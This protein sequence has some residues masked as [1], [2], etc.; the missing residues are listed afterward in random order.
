MFLGLIVIWAILGAI[1][2]AIASGKGREFWAWFIYG[3]FLFP[4]AL[5]HILVVH[6]ELSVEE[7]A[8]AAAL[9]IATERAAG[10]GRVACPHCAEKILPE[11]KVCRYCGRDVIPTEPAAAAP[12][13][14]VPDNI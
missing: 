9:R 2:G 7:V 14:F 4:I 3:F 10:A 13:E 1:V 8:H 12:V 11:A 5:I 6:R